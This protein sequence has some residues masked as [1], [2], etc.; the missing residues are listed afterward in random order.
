M[1]YLKGLT[2]KDV[3]VNPITVNH[4]FLFTAIESYSDGGN[5]TQFIGVNETYITG[6]T[7][8]S[9]PLVYNSVK[10]L[11]YGN[12][13]P[14][15][16]GKIA[17]ASLPQYNEDGTITGNVH[18]TIYEN[19]VSSINELRYFPTETGSKVRV[20]QIPRKFFGDYIQPGSFT[21]AYFDDDGEGNLVNSSDENVGN[22]LYG[23][24]I[25]IITDADEQNNIFQNISFKSS[26]TLYETQYKCTIEASEFNYSM[27]PS[28]LDSSI[29]GQ[30]KILESGSA[31]YADF[32][33]GSVF[34]PYVTTVGLYNDNK[35]LIAVGKL[36]QPLP[37][38][39]H[40]DTTI[41]VNIDR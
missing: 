14:G 18:N 9:L 39:Q 33:T 19:N 41:L 23:S 26:Y 29:K 11:Y 6:S 17:T 13:L 2:S 32:V 30:N 16:S 31:Q 40:A 12:F 10:Q 28:L 20:L 38:S 25:A 22:I 8:G 1:S 15:T 7:T 34:T 5:P 24:G 37:L 3:I 36:A 4:S 27:N 21:S 35:E